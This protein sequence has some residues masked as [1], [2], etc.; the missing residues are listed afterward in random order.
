MPG[1][2]HAQWYL[3]ECT[4]LVNF[5]VLFLGSGFCLCRNSFPMTDQLMR[6]LK[7]YQQQGVLNCKTWDVSNCKALCLSV[8]TYHFW[9]WLPVPLPVM[10]SSNP[11]WYDFLCHYWVW[12]PV[13]LPGMSSGTTSGH[14]LRYPFRV[15]LPVP[16]LGMTSSPLP[17]MTSGNFGC[18]F[19]SSNF[20]A[21]TS[22]FLFLS[23]SNIIMLLLTG[24]L[25]LH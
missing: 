21:E 16:L 22:W 5:L 12:I 4:L 24:I 11:S 25:R 20:K 10:S 18:H 8:C 23:L 15:W 13:P 6:C 19:W 3:G 2:T 9:E 1:L 14:D 7:R 17:G